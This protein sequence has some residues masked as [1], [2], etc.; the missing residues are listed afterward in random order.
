MSS[1]TKDQVYHTVGLNLRRPG[2]ADKVLGHFIMS[3]QPLWS[4]AEEFKVSVGRVLQ[5]ELK[6]A[7]RFVATEPNDVLLAEQ[8]SFSADQLCIE[9]LPLAA[10]QPCMSVLWPRL[11]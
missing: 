11:Q 10:V 7:Q 2:R 4:C 3:S 1:T 6:A 9:A 8:V 5:A